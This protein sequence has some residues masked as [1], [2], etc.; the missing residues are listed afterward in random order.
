M[1][2]LVDKSLPPTFN[3][4]LIA[5]RGEIACRVIRTARELGVKTV[6][7][8]SDADV[9]AEHVQ[10]ADEA[11]RIGNPPAAESYLIGEKILEV[12]AKTGA[13]A[14]HPGYG[15]LSEN[16]DFADACAEANVKFI[17][18]PSSA[19]KAMGSKSA[20]KIIMTEAKVPVVPGYH[21]EDQSERK[22]I[23]ESK[24]IGFPL[25][26]KAVLGGG[27]KGMRIVHSEEQFLDMLHAA[28]RESMKSFKDDNVLLERYIERPRHIE[29]QVFADQHGDAVHLFERDC[30]VQRRHQKVLE[31]APAPGMSSELRA[32]MGES[33]VNAAKAVGYEG[34]GTV[35][36]IFDAVTNDYFFM[37]MNTRLQVEHP[38]S[39]MIT[40]RDLVQWQLHVAKG[41]PLPATQDS[42][43]RSV[44]GHAI[45][46]RIYA[47]DPE[48]GFLP[49]VGRL[50]HVRY[51]QTDGTLRVE[52]GIKTGDEVSMF[53]DPMIAKLVVWGNTRKAALDKCDQALENFQIIGTP[54]NISF[55]RRC[56]NHPEF[57]N[58]SVE[59][60][61]IEQ[62][63]SDLFPEKGEGLTPNERTA[64]CMA[65][66]RLLEEMERK[67]EAKAKESA[68]ARSPW[69]SRQHERLIMP[70]SFSIEFNLQNSGEAAPTPVE[71][72]VTDLGDGKLRMRVGEGEEEVEV[73]RISQ[74]DGLDL[75]KVGEVA[76]KGNVVPNG[77]ELHVFAFG[78][79]FCFDLPQASF[80]NSEMEAGDGCLSPMSGK[81]VKLL[82]SPGQEFSKGEQL[83]I[84]EAMKMEHV[85]KAPRD[86]TVKEVMCAEGDFVEG[87]KLVISFDPI[88]E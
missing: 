59:T 51:P 43:D 5:N 15:F 68:D 3:K 61:F 47:E 32:A 23:E 42:I 18:P 25:M 46:A 19:I 85:V 88:D 37:E 60:N 54:T 11:Y 38:V 34:A 33:A 35:E 31:E 14:I 44:T 69:F 87:K 41:H 78:E 84:V 12:A 49:A 40:K 74:S 20:S 9:H 67:A 27:G 65:A 62:Y 22:L 66:H 16:A 64:A 77:S 76:C 81:I 71:V 30:S 56:L 28:K 83:L 57:I 26:I 45:E 73:H 48:N 21:G 6:A 13:E 63:L 55:L 17:G 39:E 58:G 36:F 80:L 29:F 7:V 2:A 70:S 75:I 10:I 4:I 1:R 72:T 52:T 79:R 53:Y 8:Y 86:G 50:K 24:K 82:A